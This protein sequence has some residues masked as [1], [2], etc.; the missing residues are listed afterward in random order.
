MRTRILGLILLALC[1]MQSQL[2]AATPPE[3]AKLD[4]LTIQLPPDSGWNRTKGSAQQ[5]VYERTAQDQPVTLSFSTTPIEPQPENQAFFRFAEARHAQ[6]LSKLEIVT[7]HYYYGMHEQGTPCVRYDGITKDKNAQT[8]PFVSVR[9][10]L[11]RDLASSGKMIQMEVAQRS[12]TREA[13]YKVDLSE[14]TVQ[15]FGATQFTDDVAD[16][17]R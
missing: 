10:L 8:L 17:A 11:C 4:G 3:T 14:T 9:G 15:A 13:A 12:G 16:A 2:H 7:F 5:I 1:S 6:T